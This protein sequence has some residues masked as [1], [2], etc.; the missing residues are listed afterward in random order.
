[1]RYRE[2]MRAA[3]REGARAGKNAAEWAM[4]GERIDYAR[5]LSGL[6]S[7]DPAVLDSLPCLDLSGQWADGPTEAGI[8]N[9]VVVGGPC[10]DDSRDDVVNAYR[11]AYDGAVVAEVERIC[12]YHLAP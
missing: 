2:T 8:L 3:R 11:D 5:I 9:D 1:M 6:D 4:Q 7:G 10:D 12:R